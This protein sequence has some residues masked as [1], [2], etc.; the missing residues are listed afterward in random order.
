MGYSKKKEIIKFTALIGIIFFTVLTIFVF[1]IDHSQFLNFVIDFL[2]IYKYEKKVVALF[3]SNKYNILRILTLI[4]L[5]ISILSYIFRQK[6]FNILKKGPKKKIFIES[7]NK[8]ERKYWK[9]CI[10]IIVISFLIKLYY[11]I[12]IPVTYDEAWTFINFTDRGFLSSISYYPAP[13]NHVLHSLFTNLSSYLPFNKLTNL[14]I[15][16]LISISIC[17]LFLFYTFS[18][19]FK[20]KIGLSLLIIF[21]CLEP[22]NLYGFLS[23]GYSLI[24]L[25]FIICFYSSIKLMENNKHEQTKYFFFLFIASVF[26]F[27]SMPSFL[28]PYVSIITYL[29][30]I[31]IRKGSKEKIK[32]LILSC[33]S[34][35]IVVLILYAPIILFSGLESIIGNKFVDSL[36]RTEVLNSLIN[37]FIITYEFLF[38]IN[39]FYI[40]IILILSIF[41]NLKINSK[42]LLGYYFSLYTL[43]LCPIIL[44]VHSVIP[45]PRT[46]IYLI[47]PILYITGKTIHTLKKESFMNIFVLASFIIFIL[48]NFSFNYEIEQNEKYSFE[49][50]VLSNYISQEKIKKIRC[51]HPLI[52]T[53]VKFYNPDIDI[54]YSNKLKFIY[55]ENELHNMKWFLLNEKNKNKNLSLKYAINNGNKGDVYLY[56][57]LN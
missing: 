39:P 25:T 23:R 10:S 53:Y 32:K 19:L 43:L 22:V 27:Y 48:F 46:W 16:S 33:S 50:E 55:K 1:V 47:I 15:P 29:L 34:T 11:S 31:F 24:L 49:A 57:I 18:R 6:L 36:N 28:Y 7:F 14:R 52:D 3:S 21:C 38:S 41:Y 45:F 26:G 42:N 44:I 5:I 30:Y 2:D 4:L 35:L 54:V 9:Y 8:I 20:P 12:I 17:S 56:E 40:L 37:H 51:N 13:N